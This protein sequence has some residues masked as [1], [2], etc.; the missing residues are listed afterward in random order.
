MGYTKGYSERL[1][2]NYIEEIEAE[3]KK[4][5]KNFNDMDFQNAV[6]KNEFEE[7]IND[8]VK[9]CDQ[10]IENLSSYSFN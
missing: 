9:N 1:V 7:I 5:V 6:T 8:M 4:I 3:K 2:A 10:L